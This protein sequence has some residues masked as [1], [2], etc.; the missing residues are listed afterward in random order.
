MG[1]GV[2]SELVSLI[3]ASPPDAPPEPLLYSATYNQI[4][5]TWDQVYNGGSTILG[6]EILMAAVGSSNQLGK[7]V[8]TEEYIDVTSSGVLNLPYR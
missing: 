4:T 1:T 8:T 3:A 5:I 6:Y 2:D 7:N